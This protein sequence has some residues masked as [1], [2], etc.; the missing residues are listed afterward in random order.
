[1]FYSPEI[2]GADSSMMEWVEP[3]ATWIDNRSQRTSLVWPAQAECD[4]RQAEASLNML[5]MTACQTVSDDN[6]GQSIKVI[7][8]GF[9]NS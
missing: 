3:G 9:H 2:L 5:A 6:E 7:A 1:L 8:D 4:S